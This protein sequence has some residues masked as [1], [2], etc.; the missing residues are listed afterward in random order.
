MLAARSS[1]LRPATSYCDHGVVDQVRIDK[2]LWAARM[3]KT[4][5]AA[6][7]AVLGGRAHVNGERVKP[8]KVV[9]TG[10]TIE[11]TTRTVRRTLVV[12]GVAERRG[13]A[14]DALTMYEETPESLIA[15]ELHAAERRLSRPLGVD[16][17][18]RPTKQARRRLDALR[19]GQR[20]TR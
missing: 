10:D 19:R 17:G 8:S 1:I 11:V 14:S 12:T 2:W 6:T 7:A 5:S 15:R 18:T 20:G 3:F 9:R 16:L 13:P 4:R